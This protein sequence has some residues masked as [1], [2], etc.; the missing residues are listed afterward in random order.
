M[1]HITC[2]A[3]LPAVMRRNT[4]LL[5]KGDAF[6]KMTAEQWAHL[7]E[8]KPFVGVLLCGSEEQLNEVDQSVAGVPDIYLLP[9]DYTYLAEGDIVRLNPQGERIST[10]FRKSSPSN[11]ILLTERCNH[12][13]LMCSQ[14]PKR[15]DDAWLVDEALELLGLIP[16]D[17]VNIGFTGGEPTLHGERFIELVEAAK[18]NLPGTALDVLT[19]GRAFKNEAFAARLAQVRHPNLQLGIPLYSDDPVRHEYVVQAE[20]AF[21]ETIQGILNLKRYG[22]RVEIRIVVHQQ[23][24]PRL[25]QTCEFIARNLLFVDHV[26]LMGLEIT[27]FTRANLDILWADPHTYRDTLSEAVEVLRT[28]G[29]HC[30]VYNHQLCLV[31]R[32]VESVYRRSISDWKNEYL[33]Q[34]EDC[35]RKS[36]CGGF[37]STQI[38][39]RH[40]KHI[41][42][43]Q[44]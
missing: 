37:F 44:A 43:F 9:E 2:N 8:S 20:G 33:P 19:N 22:V 5:L 17:T 7:R 36:E 27:G 23:T 42:P 29:M 14:P 6:K 38:L 10:L 34:C 35:S 25:V 1:A 24:L 32:D 28:Y 12:L 30:S 41:Q 39:H 18:L 40:S 26:A 21:D 16:R 13:C 11:S 31:N 4:A 15:V 3:Q